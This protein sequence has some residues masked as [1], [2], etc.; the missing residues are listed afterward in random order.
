MGNIVQWKKRNKTF[1]FELDSQ[2]GQAPYSD[3]FCTP[4]NRLRTCGGRVF[5]GKGSTAPPLR[6][7]GSIILPLM[8]LISNSG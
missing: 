5:R 4:P 8:S 1:L 2:R 7:A 3:I 6:Y